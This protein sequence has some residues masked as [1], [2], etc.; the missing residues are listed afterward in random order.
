A[1]D[2]PAMLRHRHGQGTAYLY[3]S[4]IKELTGGFGPAVAE[5]AEAPALRRIIAIAAD[6][7]PADIRIDHPPVIAWLLDGPEQTVLVLMNC[8]DT[9]LAE[10]RVDVRLPSP[11]ST[12]VRGDGSALALTTDG[13]WTTFR[14]PLASQDG[15]II[16]LRR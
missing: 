15:D 12:A 4:T 8:A 14:L 2:A 6:R 10:I 11:A 5:T 1:D 9:D 3:G 13:P 16:V 7:V